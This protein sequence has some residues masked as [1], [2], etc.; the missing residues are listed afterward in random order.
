MTYNNDLV[1]WSLN[2]LFLNNHMNIQFIS[3]SPDIIKNPKTTFF[4]KS[5]AENANSIKKC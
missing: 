3:D 4:F 1:V 2:K 5:C